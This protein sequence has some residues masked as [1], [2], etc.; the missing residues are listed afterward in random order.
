MKVNT[1]IGL[2]EDFRSREREFFVVVI[3]LLLIFC[4]VLWKRQA[5]LKANGNNP[6]ESED[7]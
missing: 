7:L 5:F 6:N 4:F 2:V 3:Y 1:E